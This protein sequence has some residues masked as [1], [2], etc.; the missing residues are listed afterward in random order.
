MA[1]DKITLLR[2]KIKRIYNKEE[3]T[4]SD[5]D[6]IDELA[7]EL[8]KELKNNPITVEISYKKQLNIDDEYLDWVTDY[9]ID[10]DCDFMSAVN[11][12]LIDNS[13]LRC[14]LFDDCNIRIT[15][16]YGN[17]VIVQG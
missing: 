15:D 4:D 3:I 12:D 17:K 16:K 14:E 9:M 11:D 13:D 6:K 1:L 5:Y 7:I 2:N 8:K 10:N